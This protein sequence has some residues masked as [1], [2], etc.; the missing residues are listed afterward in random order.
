LGDELAFQAQILKGTRD[1]LP[2]RM[3]LRQ[4]VINKLQTVFENFGFEPLDT[5]AIEYAEVL[6]G[7]YGEEADK[8][9]YRFEDRGGRHIGL[10]YDLTVPLARVVATHPEL[11]R[12][13]KRYQ[14][15]PVWRA[16]KPQKGRYREFWQCDVDTVG[17]SSMLA[18]AEVICVA[19]DALRRLG[20]E[21]FRIKINN[22]KI[23]AAIAEHIG[24][25]SE[26]AAHVFRS[27]DKLDKIGV[28]GVRRELSEGG[29]DSTL[30]E[31]LLQFLRVRDRADV[32]LSELASK[33]ADNLQG[34]EGIKELGELVQQLQWLGVSDENFEIDCSM[35]R[36]LDY[37]TGPIFETVVEEPKIGSIS[38]GGRYDNLVGLFVN[39]PVPATGVSLGLERI[40]DVLEELHLGDVPNLKTVTT[41]LVT[42]FGP[43]TLGHSLRLS[44]ELRGAD[45]QTEVY[46]GKDKL[47]NQ[48]RYASRKGIPYAVILGPDEIAAG[49]VLVK[50]M[51]SEQQVTLDQNDVVAYIRSEK[52]TVR[53]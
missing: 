17:S 48:L 35:V 44:T 9:L 15:A 10:R 41:A 16:E 2:E 27:I 25:A 26:N 38:G 46:L 21:R 18:D 28:E 20:F 31:K 51:A 40:V 5:P 36:G 45:I 30:I 8:L 22:R 19:Y 47:G 1:F 11:A 49:R 42:V 7:K 6:E 39:R 23:L 50:N 13:F 4:Y 34:V 53:S 33:L 3:I 29:L 37:Y 24:V 12:P 52:E 43:E 32:V 14:I